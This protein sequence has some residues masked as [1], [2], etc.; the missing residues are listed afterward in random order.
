MILSSS[1]RPSCVLPGGHFYMVRTGHYHFGMT[2]G[3]RAMS[4]TTCG[5]R[6]PV[7]Y[8]TCAADCSNTS[9]AEPYLEAG[10]VGTVVERPRPAGGG[11]SCVGRCRTLAESPADRRP[12]QPPET[13]LQRPCCEWSARPGCAETPPPPPGRTGGRHTAVIPLQRLP[14]AGACG[15]DGPS[16][17]NHTCR[18]RGGCAPRA[19]SRRP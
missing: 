18:R 5:V 15:T 6:R 17:S 11:I 3:A 19:G 13:L 1:I 2:P 8:A 12:H 4:P 16:P 10:A 7:D 9:L 14:P